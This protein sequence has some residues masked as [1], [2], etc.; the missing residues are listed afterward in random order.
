MVRGDR[1]VGWSR[2]DGSLIKDSVVS[3]T[4]MMVMAGVA[5]YMPA[6]S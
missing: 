3:L 1:V 5:A 4:W 2:G 6:T